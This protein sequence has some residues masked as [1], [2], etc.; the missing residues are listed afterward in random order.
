[1][2]VAKMFNE[3]LSNY[4]KDNKGRSL[5]SEASVKDINKLSA[6]SRGLLENGKMYSFNYYTES[7]TFYDSNPI[8]IGLGK[9]NSIN[10]S[11]INLH[12]M[13]YDI[14]KLFLNDLLN[15]LGTFISSE[16][17]GSKLGKPNTQRPIDTLDWDLLQST[18]GNKYNL[19]YCIRQYRLD[20]MYNPYVIGYENWHLGCVHDKNAF[21]GGNIIKSQA[22]YYK[23]V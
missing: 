5:A 17:N 3:N 10:Q 15:S 22:L 16:I 4:L 21:I 6:R 7:D 2:D 1:M 9:I 23:N 11:A 12:F 18:L 19:K 14:R 13:P 20:K 8:V